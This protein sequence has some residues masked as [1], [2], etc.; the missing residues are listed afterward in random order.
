MHIYASMQVYTYMQICKNASMYLY[1]SMQVCTYASIH[2]D[3]SMQICTYMQVCMYTNKCE[4]I[5]MSTIA[6]FFL[7]LDHQILKY[8]ESEHENMFQSI[9]LHSYDILSLHLLHSQQVQS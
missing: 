9:L 2:I 3:S 8:Y 6:A 7:N 4:A 5:Y 1:A